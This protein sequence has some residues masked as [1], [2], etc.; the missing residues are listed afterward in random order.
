MT[1]V[2]LGELTERHIA[3][4]LELSADPELV[5]TMGWRPFGPGETSRFLE[6]A[7]LLTLPYCHQDG[8][9]I[10]S[11]VNATNDKAVGYLSVKGINRAGKSAEIGIAVMEKACRSRGFGG[12]ALRLAVEYA[13]GE[14]GLA[15]LGLTV[16]PSNQR[17]IGAYEKLGFRK[18]ELL[19]NSWQMPDGEYADMWLMEL[20]SDDW[21][22]AAGSQQP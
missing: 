22:H 4:F 20:T 8:C 2:Y 11:I 6:A 17:A 13:F 21:R 10:F 3:R 18:R 7:R 9:H 14:M 15:L 12:E 1:R 19:E 5:D 16:F